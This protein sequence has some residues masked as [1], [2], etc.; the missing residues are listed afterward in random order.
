M[1][2]SDSLKRFRNDFKLSQKKIAD[3]LN[4]NP[5]QYY[6]YESG[7]TVPLATVILKIADAFDVST[8]YLFGRIDTPKPQEVGAE[9]VREAREFKAALKKFVESKGGD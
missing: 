7:E 6:R 1:T 8:D 5:T 2:L 9:E 4:M 3:K